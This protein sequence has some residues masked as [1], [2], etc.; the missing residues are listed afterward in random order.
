[1]LALNLHALAETDFWHDGNGSIRE[2]LVRGR[3]P[4]SWVLF[5]RLQKSGSSSCEGYISNLLGTFGW[6]HSCSWSAFRCQSC[7]AFLTSE[8]ESPCAE[9]AGILSS[10]GICGIMNPPRLIV[11]NAP[12]LSMADAISIM[13]VPIRLPHVLALTW[14]RHPITRVWS[15]YHFIKSE[16]GWDYP[17]YSKACGELSLENWLLCDTAALGWSNRQVRMLGG[18]PGCAVPTTEA[19][20]IAK[21]N[22]VQRFAWFGLLECQRLSLCLLQQRLFGRIMFELELPMENFKHGST[23]SQV[24]ESISPAALAMVRER[25]A[26]DMHLVHFAEEHLRLRSRGFP[27][28]ARERCSMRR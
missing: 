22:L 3:P 20:D 25:N 12:H 15:E 16:W 2:E 7:F 8:T 11:E 13:P 18:D 27:E 28:C 21:R 19:L 10:D 5:L 24:L 23:W 14:M 6:I 9:R 17:N 1:M 4:P 26:L